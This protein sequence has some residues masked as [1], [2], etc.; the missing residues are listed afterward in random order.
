MS[1]WDLSDGESAKDTGTG[2]E[3]PGGGNFDPIPEGSSLLALPDEVK[4][5]SKDEANF[6]SIRWSVLSPDEYKN[7]K[8]FHKLYVTDL[9]PSVKDPEKAKKKRDKARRMLSAIDANA[10][11]ALSASNEA[12]TNDALAAALQNKPMIITVQVW[13]LVDRN[14]GD[15]IMGNWVCAVNPSDHGVDIKPTNPKHVSAPKSAASG[16]GYSGG[17]SADMDDE[18]PF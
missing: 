18:I 16:G 5:D 15:K 10:G 13:D 17:G 14:T 8:V 4:W 7:R 2:Y 11:G 6:I 12:P 1:F 9:D 3:I